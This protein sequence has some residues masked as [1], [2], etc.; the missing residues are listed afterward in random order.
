[1]FDEIV[2]LEREP[3]RGMNYVPRSG[4]NGGYTISYKSEGDS[5]LSG[6]S[7]WLVSDVPNPVDTPLYENTIIPGQRSSDALPNVAAECYIEGVSAREV[8]KIFKLVG[9]ETIMSIQVSNSSKNLDEGFE[10]W[11]NSDF[12][13]FLYLYLDEDTRNCVLQVMFAMLPF[14]PLSV[15]TRRVIA[16]FSA[17]LYS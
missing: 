2:R 6:T 3:T 4:K 9:V 12:G 14:L 10:S 17:Y 5:K 1:M 13:E 11:R 15:L 7:N 8:N 16:V